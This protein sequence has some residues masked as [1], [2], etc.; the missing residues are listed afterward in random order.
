MMT[1]W[2]WPEA[3]G[4]DHERVCRALRAPAITVI[5]WL[6]ATA[7]V[8]HCG[9]RMLRTSICEL[10]QRRG[11]RWHTGLGR[12]GAVAKMGL[13]VAGAGLLFEYVTPLTM[14]VGRRGACWK[15]APR[16]ALW[17]GDGTGVG[18]WRRATLWAPTP[19]HGLSPA[20]AWAPTVFSPDLRCGL[21]T[22]WQGQPPAARGFSGASHM[23]VQ[24]HPGLSRVA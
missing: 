7:L 4:N 22:R 15:L 12:S 10:R 13:K 19:R 24:G 8:E 17:R 3:G 21:R 18:G 9:C 16:A 6:D 14:G 20:R 1:Q 23:R 11:P 2:N 5:S